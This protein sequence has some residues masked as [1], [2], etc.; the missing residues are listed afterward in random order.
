MPLKITSPA[1]DNQANIPAQYT[2]NGKNH[3]PALSWS[4]GPN[5]TQ[6]YVLIMDDPDAPNGTWVHWVL[7]NI[8]ANITHLDTATEMPA[9]AS[10]G[11]NSYEQTGYRGPCPPTGTHRYF[12]K[13]Y[14][15]DKKLNINSRV[16][17]EEVINA[18]QDNILDSGEL[19]GL[20]QQ[21]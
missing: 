4:D 21:P 14:A 2:C 20:Y 17:K 9:G 11:S 3:S 18:M 12:F 5:G 10:S 6:S 7:F 19:I 16:T 1:F 13:L 8:P 15:L